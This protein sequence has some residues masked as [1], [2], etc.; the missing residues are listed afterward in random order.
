MANPTI[1]FIGYGNMAQAIAE[2]RFASQIVPITLKTR[3][4]EV[5]FDTD[6]HPRATTLE[7]LA[8]MK[9]AFKRDGGT[10][11]AGNASGINEDRKSV[12]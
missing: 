8:K 10:V 2:G 6:E 11:T 5:V 1:G 12:V 4:G 7:A 9:P 3:K